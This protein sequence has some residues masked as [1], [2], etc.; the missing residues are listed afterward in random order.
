MPILIENL[1]QVS[2]PD[3]ADLQKIYADAPAALLN[4]KTAEAL[5]NDCLDSEHGFFIAGRFNSKL[6]AAIQA[7]EIDD[8]IILNALCVR[9]ITRRRGIARRLIET[10]P[11]HKNLYCLN[12]VQVLTPVLKAQGFSKGEYRQQPCWQRLVNT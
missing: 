11:V 5:V 2:P 8:A 7:R 6:V 9:H 10:L 12:S 1:H 3:L 4:H